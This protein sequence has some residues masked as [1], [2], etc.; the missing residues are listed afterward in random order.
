[1]NAVQT[2]IDGGSEV[3]RYLALNIVF[4]ALL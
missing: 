2:K 3:I 1:M 4:V